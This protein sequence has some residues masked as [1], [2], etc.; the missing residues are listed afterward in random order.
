MDLLECHNGFE[1]DHKIIANKHVQNMPTN[2][3]PAVSYKN[4]FLR[5]KCY[6][7][8]VQL[9]PK[10]LLVNTLQKTRTKLPVYLYRGGNHLAR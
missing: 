10:C 5:L 7:S 2:N 6:S 3:L 9:K 1:L 8:T 4:L